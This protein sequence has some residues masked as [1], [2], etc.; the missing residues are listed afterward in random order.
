MPSYY[1]S[2]ARGLAMTVLVTEKSR[3]QM[4]ILREAECFE[5]FHVFSFFSADARSC[6][7]QRL[8]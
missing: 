1:P 2:G 8:N 5:Y 7:L 3:S 4:R 6:A